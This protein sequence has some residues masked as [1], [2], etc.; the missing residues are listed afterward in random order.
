MNKQQLTNF[1]INPLLRSIPMGYTGR[2]VMAIQ[3]II[4]HESLR[5]EYLTQLDNGPA[6]GWI[7][8]ERETHR[9]VWVYGATCWDNALKAGIIDHEQHRLQIIPP[10]DRLL[11]DL[12]YNIFMAR[13]RLFMKPEA[14]PYGA[15]AMS[16]YLKLH[17]N[18]IYGAADDNSYYLDWKA[19]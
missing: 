13:Q 12:R 18:S 11:Y 16:A 19:W 4:A 17:W 15:E 9:S 6:A 7:G 8:M 14:L 2:A 1:V 5:G 10:F 3:M